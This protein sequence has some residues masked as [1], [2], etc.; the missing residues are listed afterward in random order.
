MAS[1]STRIFVSPCPTH[2]TGPFGAQICNILAAQFPI[3]VPRWSA[4]RIPWKDNVTV[5]VDAIAAPPRAEDYCSIYMPKIQQALIERGIAITL[6][7]SD[8]NGV[9]MM[10]IVGKPFDEATVLKIG[11]AYQQ[12]VDWQLRVPPMAQAVAA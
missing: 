5:T 6:N 9:Q 2:P 7:C 12:L 1:R 3:L 8:V 11:D 4:C 10:Q